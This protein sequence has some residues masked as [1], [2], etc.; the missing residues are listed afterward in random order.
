MCAMAESILTEI[1]GAVALISFN[2]PERNNSMTDEMKFGYFDLLDEYGKDPQVRAIVLTGAGKSFCVGA[3]TQNLAAIDPS[4]I[5]DHPPE[6]RPVTYPLTTRKPII[7]AI[8]GA[9]AGVGLVHALCC[10]IRFAAAGAKMT[11]AFARRGLIAEYGSS[12]L[13]PRMIGTPRAFDLIVSG[14]VFK[15]EEAKEL[16]VVNQVCPKEEVVDAAMEYAADIA[17]NC[18]PL[19]MSIMKEQ[20][21]GDLVRDLDDAYENAGVEMRASLK[22]PD[23]KEG[24]ASFLERRPPNF[25][26]LG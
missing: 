21:Y 13:L 9:C 14:R 24:V 5:S 4:K 7:C 25:P 1:R 11:T 22:R 20:I 12:W 2:R 8:N 3:D 16:G 19:S 26:G 18:A 6:Q 17:Q 10:D 15:S 23:L